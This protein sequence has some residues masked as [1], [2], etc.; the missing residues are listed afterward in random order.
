MPGV[1]HLAINHLCAPPAERCAAGGH[2]LPAGPARPRAARC[3][4]WWWGRE[5]LSRCGWTGGTSK[6]SECGR[7]MVAEPQHLASVLPAADLWSDHRH[8][9]RAAAPG[10][11]AGLPAVPMPLAFA[12]WPPARSLRGRGLVVADPLA[13]V[14]SITGT[15]PKPLH[16]MLPRWLVAAPTQKGVRVTGTDRGH[17]DSI[18]RLWLNSLSDNKNRPMVKPARRRGQAGDRPGTAGTREREKEKSSFFLS[19]WSAV[20][21]LSASRCLCLPSAKSAGPSQGFNPADS[22]TAD[23]R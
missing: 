2:A 6:H 19:L 18:S 20:S 12:R 14:W 23:P 1:V 8:A 15:L 17:G 4:G 3:A 10:D 22:K 16:P 13:P 5:T 21:S 9:A 7:C 11:A